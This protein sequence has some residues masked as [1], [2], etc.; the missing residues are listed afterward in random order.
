MYTDVFWCAFPTL[1]CPALPCTV[2][3]GPLLDSTSGMQVE[4]AAVVVPRYAIGITSSSN[5]GIA[6]GTTYAVRF[7]LRS[8]FSSVRLTQITMM[9]G[10]NGIAVSSAH[11]LVWELYEKLSTA[12]ALTQPT[13]KATAK[14]NLTNW[15]TAGARYVPVTLPSDVAWK[16]TPG[17]TYWLM[18]KY[19]QP[20]YASTLNM[21]YLPLVPSTGTD[22]WWSPN[23]AAGNVVHGFLR[24]A[25]ASNT[26]GALVAAAGT[27]STSLPYDAPVISLKA[28]SV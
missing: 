26:A 3:E 4:P 27:S 6:D 28:A 5:F 12:G 8:D 2:S 19:T 20:Q 25:L 15:N 10:V 17:A 1:P 16:L 21:L 22:G 24:T 23:L 7:Q 9:V 14:T 18:F 13:L 11:G